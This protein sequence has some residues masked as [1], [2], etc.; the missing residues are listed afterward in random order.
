VATTETK[1]RT[2]AIQRLRAFAGRHPLWLVFSGLTALALAVYLPYAVK[3]GWYYDDWSV[4]AELRDRHGN[5]FQDMHTCTQTIPA[6][7]SLTCLYHVTEYSLFG[8]HRWLYHLLAIAFLVVL[9]V[10]LVRILL[11]CRVPLLWAAL[12]GALLIVFPASDATRLWPVGAIGQYVLA[13]QLLGVLLALNAL[14]RPPGT[15]RT[16]LHIAA[17]LL[18]VVAMATYEVVVPLVALSGLFYV[19]AYRNRPAVIR[20]LVDLGLAIAF[21]IW[22]LAINPAAPDSGFVVHRNL[23]GDIDRVRALLHGAWRSWHFTYLPGKLAILIVPLLLAAVIAGLLDRSLG[24][25]LLPWGALLVGSTIVAAASALVFFTA[26][27]IYLLN[28][29]GLFNRLNLPGSIAYVMAFIALLGIGYELVRRYVPFRWA[30]P[31]AVVVVAGGVAW[32]QLGISTDH[33]RAFE[34]SWQEQ[35]KALAGYAMAVRGLPRSS[36][37][38]GFDTPLWERGYIP[39]FSASWDLRGAVDYTTRVNP[40]L[41][42]PFVPGTGCGTDGVTEGATTFAPYAVAGQPLYFVSPNRRLAV[43]VSTPQQCA[44]TVARFGYPPFWGRTVTG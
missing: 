10:L 5:W 22:R 31:L 36:R 15:R 4:Y 39:V 26:N 19:A 8:S 1:Q 23:H 2:P 41:A 38:I 40:P 18:F 17:G 9:A 35:K 21:T 6:G 24:R 16:L 42:M 7:R 27:D 37:I 43:R 29:G 30:A 25:R 3:A 14:G 12:A 11:Y 34:V 32:H 33:K 44:R 20:G 13:L 28:V